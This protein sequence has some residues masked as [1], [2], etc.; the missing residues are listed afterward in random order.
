MGILFLFF[1]YII[2]FFFRI[3]FFNFKGENFSFEI[4]IN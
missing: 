1:M 2:G 4:I 3:E